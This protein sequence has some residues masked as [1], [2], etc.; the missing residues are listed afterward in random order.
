[1]IFFHIEIARK[2]HTFF[3]HRCTKIMQFDSIL[4]VCIIKVVIIFKMVIFHLKIMK[5]Y[6]RVDASLSF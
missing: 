6:S 3:N 2:L 5:K 4:L 1:M